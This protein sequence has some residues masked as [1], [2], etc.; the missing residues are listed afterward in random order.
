MKKID[1]DEFIESDKPEEVIVGILAGKFKDKPQIIKKVKER[2]VK[3]VKNEEEIAKYIDS[4]SFLAGLFDIEIKVKP[5]PIEVDIRKTF[6]YK[7]GEKEGEQRGFE[8]GKQEGLKE[9][10][11]EG[12]LGIVQAKFGSQ[13]AKLI[14]NLLDKINDISRLKKNKEENNRSKNLG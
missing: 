12:I 14:K 2:I 11:K 6:L 8:K 4:I 3:I 1:P 13:K 7:W 9:G 10:L 5:M